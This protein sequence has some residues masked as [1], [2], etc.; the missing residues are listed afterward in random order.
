MS[1]SAGV[2]ARTED[3]CAASRACHETGVC[4]ARWG[5]CVV[6]SNLDCWVSDACHVRGEC[7][8]LDGVCVQGKRMKIPG[9]AH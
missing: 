4:S 3:D 9:T 8:V 5:F 1:I 7:T 6:A 2:L